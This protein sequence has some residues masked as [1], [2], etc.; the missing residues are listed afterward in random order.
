MALTVIFQVMP[1]NQH[2]AIKSL[3]APALE[4]EFTSC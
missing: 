1:A 2:F 4:G 3:K